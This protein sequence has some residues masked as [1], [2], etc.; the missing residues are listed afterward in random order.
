MSIPYD[1]QVNHSVDETEHVLR[2]VVSEKY[3]PEEKDRIFLALD[4][5][6]KYHAGQGRADGSPYVVHP[7]RVALLALAYDSPI[8]DL[9]VTALLHDVLEET[10]MSE[11]ELGETVGEPILTYLRAVTGYK[12]SNESQEDRMKRKVEKWR[13]EM[14]GNEVVRKVK[15]FDNLDNMISWKFIDPQSPKIRKMPR[16]LM[17]AR[18]MFLPLAKI[19]NE[20]AYRLSAE[21]L[22]YYTDRGYKPGTWYS[23]PITSS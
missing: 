23:D 9:L 12:S 13:A 10:S 17:Q 15:V 11:Q 14:E 6:K 4:L 7:M 21:E 18:D 8:A 3:G 22:Q 16:W 1:F 5:A 2:A 20:D 19:T